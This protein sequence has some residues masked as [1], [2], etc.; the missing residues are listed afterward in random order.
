MKMKFINVALAVIS[1]FALLSCND[2][3]ADDAATKPCSQTSITLNI[4]TDELSRATQVEE[5]AIKTITAYLFVAQ[6]KPMAGTLVPTTTKAV[7]NGSS[8][9]VTI[10]IHN[11]D[12]L[13][14]SSRRVEIYLL[15][16]NPPLT[17]PNDATARNTYLN[18]ALTSGFDNT[19]TGANF[20]GLVAETNVTT[21]DIPLNIQVNWPSAI[22]LKRVQSRI[23]VS[24]TKAVN[25]ISNGLQGYTLSFS[26]LAQQAVVT[27][28]R[29]PS[30]F[31]GV[32][33]NGT[34]NY[35]IKGDNSDENFVNQEPVGY[36]YPNPTEK[37]VTV[38]V[39]DLN[40]NTKST[41][42]VPTAGKNYRVKVTPGATAAELA[43]SV[44][45]W[46][47]Y[48]NDTRDKYMV[49][50]VS[51]QSNSVGYDESPVLID[52]IS[53]PD[54]NAF[55][56]AYRDLTG[57]NLNIVPLKSRSDNLQDMS[58]VGPYGPK[59]IH[60][61]LAKELLKRIPKGYK[62]LV[63]PVAYGG[64]AFT[65]GTI[66]NSYDAVGM[67]P[68]L[69]PGRWGAG[70]PY[71]KTVIDRTKY[72]L[73]LNPENKFLGVVWCQGEFDK[74]ASKSQ[75]PAFDAM[76]KEFFAAIN[77]TYADRCPKGVA[78][79]DLWYNCS[80]TRYWHIWGH[81]D[82]C[83][84][85]FGGYKVWNPNT[86]IN[87]PLQTDT[88]ATNG[89]GATSGNRPTHF[90]ND[91]FSTVIAPMVAQCM[92]EN[93]GLFNGNP[94][95]AAQRFIE[96]DIRAA[97]A[98]V[99]GKFTDADI[100]QQLLLFMPFSTKVSENTAPASGG[101][102]VSG[103]IN[104]N[105]V[106]DVF[107]DV[108]GNRRTRQVLQ[109]TPS[110]SSLTMARQANISGAWSV[111]FMVKRTSS[112]TAAGHLLANHQPV[113]Y[114]TN[115]TS[116]FFGYKTFTANTNDEVVAGGNVEFVAERLT[117]SSADEGKN[118]SYAMPGRFIDADNVRTMDQWIHYVMTFD[119]NNRTAIYINGQLIH[120]PSVGGA[121]TLSPY[122]QFSGLAAA[123]FTTLYIG[124]TTKI[125]N[126]LGAK[127]ADVGIWNKELTEP[128]VKKL[129]LYS[130]YGYSRP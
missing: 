73:S 65:T 7:I 96:K 109:I 98:T 46:E 61:P 127:L 117:S 24:N 44:E 108:N 120:F 115:L 64:T 10:F 43:V 15:A 74:G 50:V 75:Y 97:A 123:D 34:Y 110:S 52:G 14:V 27:N 124:K 58:Y 67:K 38:T 11:N 85:I 130:Y 78:D 104:N 57:G 30:N 26:N 121:I 17:L 112:L 39:T 129:Y 56:L 33:Y 13:P 81:S 122:V 31:S 28:P 37:P 79:K 72:A 6:G 118:R 103:N 83:S 49:V 51:G 68:A 2:K 32:T 41:T 106:S 87:V 77:S 114:G 125:N 25:D 76:T 89:T 9:S 90:G 88:N 54:P 99:G 102:A 101:Y 92:D 69:A 86:F 35:T 107:M 48:N 55:Q 21:I 82:N 100:Q 45:L 1:A 63:I 47:G 60:L 23:F 128:T 116:P 29:F 40:K 94:N 105:L 126:T 18:N 3:F 8:A 4:G 80:S 84:D 95:I 66:N 93:G 36:I 59:G 70:T 62:I 53:K 113:L 22:V 119:G 91:A 111:A 5:N 19:A 16:N 71:A 12:A 42:F 20:K